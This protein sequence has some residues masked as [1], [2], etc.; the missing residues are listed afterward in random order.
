M[1]RLMSALVRSAFKGTA[2]LT[3]GFCMKKRHGA[4]QIEALLN[5]ADVATAVFW[6][7]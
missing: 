7:L 4:E 5:Q 6:K 3:K 2:A 1:S